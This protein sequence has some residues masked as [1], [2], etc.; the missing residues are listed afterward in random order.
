[1]KTAL[2]QQHQAGQRIKL[3]PNRIDV[4]GGKVRN[5]CKARENSM[6]PML[7][8]LCNRYLARESVKGTRW[9]GEKIMQPCACAGNV[10]WQALGKRTNF[11]LK[12]LVMY[13]SFVPRHL[14]RLCREGIAVLGQFC[15]EVI[16]WCVY[17]YIKCS[18]RVMNKISNKFHLGALTVI[19]LLVIFVD[20]ALK[21]DK[22]EPTFS[23]LNPCPSLPSV[24]T[25][26]S[27]Q[28]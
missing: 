8:E 21:L 3:A 5:L 28:F 23:S 15:V 11:G 25:D 20:I 10:Q 17:L 24:A 12:D 18:C 14:R 13:F 9:P 1:M 19:I 26:D 22:I 6:Q 16:S 4:K 27:E 7:G 2:Y